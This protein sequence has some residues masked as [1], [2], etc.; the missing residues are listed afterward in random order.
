MKRL[1][2]LR[3]PWRIGA[4]LIGII[5]AG[6][7]FILTTSPAQADQFDNQADDPNPSVEKLN[8][9][10]FDETVP[11]KVWQAAR[12]GLSPFLKAIPPKQSEQYGF[13]PGNGFG[14]TSL[15]HPYRVMTIDP[16]VLMNFDV[17]EDIR[18]R[19]LPTQS[20]VF[21]IMQNGEPR[22]ILTVGFLDDK[23]QAVAIG[24]AEFAR[25]LY[26][27]ERTWADGKGYTTTLVRIYQA[28]SDVLLLTKNER[29][30]VLPMESARVCLKLG[31][32]KDG[33]KE[34]YSVPEIVNKLAPVVEEN[35]KQSQN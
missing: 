33:A 21:P 3:G 29:V 4:V 9:F 11:S 22:A 5:L 6:A 14:N 23:W 16:Q 8:Q 19:L 2:M 30:D 13:P 32:V 18:T 20:W 7:V 26:S 15:G 12:E 1:L 17:N 35:I 31:S 28:A 27:L 25:D 24:H 10:G 34:L